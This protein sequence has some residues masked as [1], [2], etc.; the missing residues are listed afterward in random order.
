[1]PRRAPD[2]VTEHRLTLG[3]LE[4]SLLQDS[5][6]ELGD[7]PKEPGI[8]DFVKIADAVSKLAVPTVA[9]GVGILG[10]KVYADIREAVDG[11]NINPFNKPLNNN[12]DLTLNDVLFGSETP[13]PISGNA[14]RLVDTEGQTLE[15]PKNPLAG[16]PVGG[17]F[18]LGMRIGQTLNPF[19]RWA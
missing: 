17:L 12:T 7:G 10:I 6:P 8:D 15:P 5:L 14:V 18:G 2:Q 11:I 19:T 13:T 9:L 3:S 16:T 4:R 1:M